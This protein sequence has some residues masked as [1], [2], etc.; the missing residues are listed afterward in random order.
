MPRDKGIGERIRRARL[1][2]GL[3]QLR[4]CE[5]LGLT[6]G[7]VTM[8][9]LGKRTPTIENLQALCRVLMIH[10]AEL[11]TDDPPDARYA[12]VVD[13]PD[14]LMMLR[15]YRRL[16]PRARDNIRELLGVAADVC[17]DIELQ[18]EPA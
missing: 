4:L 6:D 16:G 8:W 7:V 11:L 5:Q 15:Q 18:R 3:T 2:A 17:R 14:E 10:P 1:K 13:A 9:E 12:A